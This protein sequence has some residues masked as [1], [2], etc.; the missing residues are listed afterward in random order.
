MSL[1][2]SVEEEIFIF[3][4]ETKVMYY[5]GSRGHDGVIK[6]YFIKIKTERSHYNILFMHSKIKHIGYISL[7]T[8]FNKKI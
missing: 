8:S 3:I 1:L 2:D 5:Y 4:I 7:V 6:K